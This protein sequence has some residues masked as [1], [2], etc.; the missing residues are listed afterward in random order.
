MPA[1]GDS[2]A[3]VC[4]EC[5][6]AGWTVDLVECAACAGAAAAEAAPPAPP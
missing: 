4:A 5:H 1:S 2:A 6:G 3:D